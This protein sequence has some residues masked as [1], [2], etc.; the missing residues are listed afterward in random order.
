MCTVIKLPTINNILE[1]MPPSFFFDNLRGH[2]GDQVVQLFLLRICLTVVY[3][4]WLNDVADHS[5][6]LDFMCQKVVVFDLIPLSLAELSLRFEVVVVQTVTR[7]ALLNLLHRF[8]DRLA[9]WGCYTFV[10]EL[11]QPLLS[12]VHTSGLA[13]R[14]RFFEDASLLADILHPEPLVH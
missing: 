6:L 8:L 4:G 14:H 3:S 12:G 9:L 5:E 11:A 10:A 7:H 13:F 1:T 2:I